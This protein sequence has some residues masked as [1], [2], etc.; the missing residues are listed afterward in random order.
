MEL[1]PLFELGLGGDLQISPLKRPWDMFSG[2]R[3]ADLKAKRSLCILAVPLD[4]AL[5]PAE[6]EALLPIE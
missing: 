3:I 1:N 4:G 6:M 2:C 5:R